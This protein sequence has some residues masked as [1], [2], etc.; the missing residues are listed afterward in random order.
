MNRSLSPYGLLLALALSAVACSDGDGA[1]RIE[2]DKASL[3]F[4]TA[5]CGG[6]AP[7]DQ[8]LM[9]KNTG[10]AAAQWSAK[11]S[12]TDVFSLV[13]NSSGVLAAGAELSLTV[14][15]RPA[16]ATAIPGQELTATLTV[17][18]SDKQHADYEVLL[19]I[20][21]EGATLALT[22]KLVDFGALP[23]GSK[24][25]EMPVQLKNTG[26]LPLKVTLTQPTTEPRLSLSWKGA[27][28]PFTLEAGAALEGLVAR[29]DPTTEGTFDLSLPIAVEGSTCGASATTLQLKGAATRGTLAV[30]PGSLD[31]GQTACGT[32]AATKELTLSNTGSGTLVVT[33][34]LG[35]GGASPYTLDASKVTIE[36]GKAAK[37]QIAPKAIPADSLVGAGLYDDALTLTTDADGDGTLQVALT[38]SAR[39]VRLAFSQ[40]SFDFA[41]V[42]LGSLKTSPLSVTNS[43]NVAVDATLTV[44]GTGYTVSPT[45]ATTIQ[46]AGSLS[47]D[48]IFTPTQVA[49]SSGTLTV[50][51]PA[52]TPLCAPLPE[53]ATLTGKGGNG[54]LIASTTALDFGTTDCG[55][56]AVAQA[57]VLS[58][59]GTHTFSWTAALGLAA[60]SPYGISP[61]SGS[62]DPGQS[63]TV[64]VTPA[65][66]PATAS[67][68][69]GAY[70]DTLIITPSGI[71]GG[72][73]LTLPL[74]QSARGAILA[75]NALT[76]LDFGSVAVGGHM[77]G[78][79]TLVNSGNLAISV[80]LAAA[81]APPF[82][83]AL[84]T[85]LTLNPT[86]AVPRTLY[87]DPAS[88]GM[89]KGTLSLTVQGTTALCAPL[90]TLPLSGKGI[91][92]E[93]GLSTATLDFGLTDCGTRAAAKTVIV[94]NTGERA[95]GFQAYVDGTSTAAYGLDLTQGTVQPGS[96]VTLTITPPL[97][98]AQS[99]TTTN[100]YADT[101]TIT[102]DIVG[103][104]THT[105]A[106][107]QTARGAI[108][109]ASAGDLA[110]SEVPAG[111]STTAQFTLQN[112]GNA[113]AAPTLSALNTA[114]S[115]SPATPTIQPS[116]AALITGTFAPPTS[117]PYSDSLV[118]TLPAGTA[119]C[120]PLPAVTLQGLALGAPPVN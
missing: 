115:F 85:P 108:L 110:F 89:A 12:S 91:D 21:T 30:Q 60:S 57:V 77:E 31:F 34:T 40:S 80:T 112:S 29:F 68:T 28:A 78:D 70:D 81:P 24:A 26:N 15:A 117:G 83:Q 82:S 1:P 14:A 48:I 64:T 96:S 99:A 17:V 109:T 116:G 75:Y 65:A 88:V 113:A 119:L 69:A 120:S 107:S 51:V 23:V 104:T 101:L 42:P 37:L 43:G 103:D 52:Q 114:F 22:P 5:R 100:L 49:T 13:G 10:T 84:T 98:P 87:F 47:A 25:I 35:K 67:I 63:A 56:T 79:V 76:A 95:F 74:R 45:A 50:A 55:G 72:K 73:T 38:Q 11:L 118:L 9:V 71:D 8:T 53:K 36:A 16:A 59:T 46:P 93:L 6:L 94:S 106:I 19:R 92:G 86:D 33:A 62:L 4:G 3:S 39:G 54:Q 58:N 27:P 41:T 44:T 105:V 97:I 2:V 32:T 7:A 90:P 102:T 20:V 18:S 61:S 66:L 111:F